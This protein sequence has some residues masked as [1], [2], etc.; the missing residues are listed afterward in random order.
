[1]PHYDSGGLRGYRGIYYSN[2][3]TSLAIGSLFSPVWI[4]LTSKILYCGKLVIEKLINLENVYL[5]DACTCRC[6]GFCLGCLIAEFFFSPM[7][8]LGIPHLVKL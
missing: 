2:S 5:E 7:G 3:T 1:M 6:W 4:L 8:G